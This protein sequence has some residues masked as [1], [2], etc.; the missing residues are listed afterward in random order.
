M[1]QMSRLSDR[2]PSDSGLDR[3]SG[4]VHAS[5]IN[6]RIHSIDRRLYRSITGSRTT[7]DNRENSQSAVL[8]IDFTVALVSLV[9]QI[10]F[11]AVVGLSCLSYCRLVAAA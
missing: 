7:G 6:I 2:P 1:E 8:T 9:K 5:V 4:A 10:T 3:L 11:S